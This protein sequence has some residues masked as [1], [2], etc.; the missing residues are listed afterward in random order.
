MQP[1]LM[2]CIILIAYFSTASSAGASPPFA[3][4]FGE[5]MCSPSDKGLDPFLSQLY[6][7]LIFLY[8]ATWPLLPVLVQWQPWPL[9]ATL[10]FL[11]L[12]CALAW[13]VVVESRG[14]PAAVLSSFLTL[15]LTGLTCYEYRAS[16]ARF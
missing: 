1:E 8:I 10:S 2:I 9:T 16:Q 15:L 5:T 6:I 12:L 14:L 13:V 11:L 4:V 3:D 7:F